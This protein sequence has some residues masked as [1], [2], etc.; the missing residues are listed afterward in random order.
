MPD[1]KIAVYMLSHLNVPAPPSTSYIYPLQSGS[2][3]KPRWD[4]YLCDN[5]GENIS[6]G[7]PWYSDVT[8][9]YWVWKNANAPIVGLFHYR[10]FLSPVNFPEKWNT[11]A[12]VSKEIASNLLGYDPSGNVFVGDLSIADIIMAPPI[13]FGP[14][15]EFWAKSNGSE[16]DWNLM[17]SVIEQLYPGEGEQL[18]AYFAEPRLT[19][20]WSI[21]IARR[22]ILSDY[23]DW[24]FPIFLQLELLIPERDRGLRIFA[25]MN[26]WLINYFVYSRRLN[27]VARS[28]IFVTSNKTDV[29]PG[30]RTTPDSDPGFLQFSK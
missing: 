3:Y 19:R 13:W 21:F 8:G 15:V 16:R 2:D 1:Q 11:A 9:L 5:E 25:C 14:I 20:L 4:Y 18:T 10:R 24:L 28:A 27:V 17:V 26:E 22:Q 6:K 23:C 29:S 30:F 12:D 7:H